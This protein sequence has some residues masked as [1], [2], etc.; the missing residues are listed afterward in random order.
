MEFGCAHECIQMHE[1]EREKEKEA[2]REN[3]SE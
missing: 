1:K 2:Y 3:M